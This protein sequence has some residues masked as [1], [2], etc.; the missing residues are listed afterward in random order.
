MRVLRRGHLFSG[1]PVIVDFLTDYCGHLPFLRLISNYQAGLSSDEWIIQTSDDTQSSK[2]VEDPNMTLEVYL[3]WPGMSGIPGIPGTRY[4]TW[5]TMVYHGLY[6]LPG[7]TWY[8]SGGL[9]SM[10]KIQRKTLQCIGSV[11]KKWL[12][13][14]PHNRVKVF[15]W[16]NIL[17]YTI[18]WPPEF[19]WKF[20]SE[21]DSWHSTIVYYI[22]YLDWEIWSKQKF[23]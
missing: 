5:Y 16:F 18:F 3:V 20:D 17:S 15:G 23:K 1:W 21:S 2:G 7:K 19:K 13:Y 11:Y 9:P 22:C 4:G 12:D 6:G 14:L 10:T 8:D